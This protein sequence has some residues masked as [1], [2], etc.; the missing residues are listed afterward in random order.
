MPFYGYHC[1]EC[2]ESF[3]RM[4]P[5]SRYDEP[6]TCACGSIAKKVVTAPEVIFKGDDWASKNGR[7]ARQMT[8]KA[9]RQSKRQE[10]RKREGGGV[11]LAPNVDG[12]RVGSWA[13][14]QSLAKSKG[15]NT[16]SYA[17]KVAAEQAAKKK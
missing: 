12:E 7:I 3:D 17:P 11:S 15:K 10:E 9:N 8:D 13:E 1:D 4:L 2:D 5:M 16:E 6:Q 14:A